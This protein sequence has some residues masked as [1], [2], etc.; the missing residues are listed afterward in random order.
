MKARKLGEKEY[1]KM[2]KI[3]NGNIVDLKLN[4]YVIKCNRLNIIMTWQ[5]FSN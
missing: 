3:E 4:M 2:R 1:Q 5:R